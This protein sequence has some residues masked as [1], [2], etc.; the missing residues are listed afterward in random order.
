VH[1]GTTGGAARNPVTELAGLIAA[2]VDARTGRV[3]IPG[4]YEDVRKLTAAER[5]G[6]ARAGFSLEA[7]SRLPTSSRACARSPM[8]WR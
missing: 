5:A 3:K 4:F 8:I 2:C 1:S 7:G 6:F